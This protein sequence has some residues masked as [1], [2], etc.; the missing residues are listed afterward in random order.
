[1]VSMARNQILP[2]RSGTS[3][4]WAEAVASTKAAGVDCADTTDA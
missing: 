1:M 2:P 3:S 4:R